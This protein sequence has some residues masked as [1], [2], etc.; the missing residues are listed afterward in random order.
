MTR[1]TKLSNR[2]VRRIA[3][4]EWSG[5]DGLRSDGRY[6]PYRDYVQKETLSGWTIGIGCLVRP[7]DDFSHG[8]SLD[9]ILALFHMRQADVYAA[10]ARHVTYPCNQSAFD[11][12]CDAGHNLGVG[13]FNPLNSHPIRALNALDFDGFSSPTCDGHCA[14]TGKLAHLQDYNR[15]EKGFDPGLLARRRLEHQWF[16]EPEPPIDQPLFT[17][18]E[19]REILAHVRQVSFNL[20]GELLDE[21]RA[22]ADR[23]RHPDT[24]PAPPPE[25]ESNEQAAQPGT[26]EVGSRTS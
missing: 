21:E 26:D 6:Y 11:A 5:K 18:D 3:G 16:W 10:I 15:S 14:T 20:T 25:M 24:I 1:P 8:L 19:Q 23:D 2:G 12:L 13:F 4:Q 22:M 9:E 7:G 17:D